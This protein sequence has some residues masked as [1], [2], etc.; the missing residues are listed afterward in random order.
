MPASVFESRFWKRSQRPLYVWGRQTFLFSFIPSFAPTSLWKEGRERKQ[1][2]KEDDA[3]SVAPPF[4]LGGYCWHGRV[5]LTLLGIGEEP[6]F[7]FC[8]LT[9]GSKKVGKRLFCIQ[10]KRGFS[11]GGNHALIIALAQGTLGT[12]FSCVYPGQ[13]QQ[14]N[15]WKKKSNENLRAVP[16]VGKWVQAKFFLDYGKSET[17]NKMRG[18]KWGLQAS[19]C[20]IF[21]C[22]TLCLFFPLLWLVCGELQ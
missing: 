17:R 21:Q 13:K 8:F 11:H 3:G 15:D 14:R 4:S 1:K 20:L 7:S 10:A 6:P 16:N 9:L 5:F 12:L 2:G 22:K 19:I 18:D